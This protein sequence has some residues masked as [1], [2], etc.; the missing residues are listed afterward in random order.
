MVV[1]EREYEGE[2]VHLEHRA[3]ILSKYLPYTA[4]DLAHRAA[5]HLRG[6]ERGNAIA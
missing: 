4:Q 6:Q 2:A 5:L 3:C 1:M